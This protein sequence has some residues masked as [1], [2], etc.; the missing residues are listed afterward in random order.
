MNKRKWKEN[1][2]EEFIDSEKIAYHTYDVI[3]RKQ[4]ENEYVDIIAST[5]CDYYDILKKHISTF[6]KAM[7]VLADDYNINIYDLPFKH[8]KIKQE[9]RRYDLIKQLENYFKENKIEYKN[10]YEEGR[11]L[12]NID[13]NIK[14]MM[15][16]INE[17]DMNLIC[18]VYD[19]NVPI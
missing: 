9:L 6:Y 13:S 10:V 5:H 12:Q 3:V 2:F 17:I 4:K 18:N 19:K 11:K 15:D 16:E 7:I 1:D 14:E 8:E